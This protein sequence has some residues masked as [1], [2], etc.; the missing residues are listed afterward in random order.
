MWIIIGVVV[1]NVHINSN[2][3]IDLLQ[4]CTQ[5]CKITIRRSTGQWETGCSVLGR[6]IQTT[7]HSFWTH[8]PTL[9]KLRQTWRRILPSSRQLI[10]VFQAKLQLLF[11]TSWLP[12]SSCHRHIRARIRSFIESASSGA[13]KPDTRSVAG[14]IVPSLAFSFSFFLSHV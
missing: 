8:G 10:G 4:V 7:H 11:W 6:K 5:L 14:A 13:D 3:V 9:V 2:Q 1:R 12:V